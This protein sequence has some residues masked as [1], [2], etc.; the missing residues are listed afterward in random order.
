MF[1][2]QVSHLAPEKCLDKPNVVSIPHLAGATSVIFEGFEK[3]WVS[4]CITLLNHFVILT[5]F[6]D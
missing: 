3:G 1:A 6:F 5:F 4:L 2:D